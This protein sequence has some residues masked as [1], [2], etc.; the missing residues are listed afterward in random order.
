MQNNPCAPSATAAGVDNPCSMIPVLRGALFDLMSGKG[1]SQIRF[2]DQWLSFHNG[3][4]KELRA[5]IARLEIMCS[6]GQPS[7]AGRAVR[8]GSRFSPS[9]YGYGRR[10]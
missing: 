8:V 3:N 1:R 2:G 5:E 6:N 9:M 7:N 10:Y 4:V